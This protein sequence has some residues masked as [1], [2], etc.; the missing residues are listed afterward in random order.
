MNIGMSRSE[1]T[2]AALL[3]QRV[4]ALGWLGVV[5]GGGR[6]RLATL[7][8]EGAAKIRMPTPEGDWIEAVLINTAGGMTGGD[9][10]AWQIDIGAGASATVT[11]QT[12]EKVYRSE[13]GEATLSATLTVGQNGRLAWLPQE[14]IVFDRSAFSRRLDLDIGEGAT[15]LLAETTL[16]GRAAMGEAVQQRPFPRPLAGAL[17]V[18]GSSMPRISSSRATSASA[19]PLPPSLAAPRPSPPF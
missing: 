10:I 11:T 13:H 18:G 7:Y 14:T 15:V 17:Q 1:T 8:Q 9:R 6:S 5:Q 16:F 19:S 3:P 2:A 12:C 4:N